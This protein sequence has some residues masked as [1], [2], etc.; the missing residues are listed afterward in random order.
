MSGV[1]TTTV[2]DRTP[3][4]DPFGLASVVA[5]RRKHMPIRLM[6][7]VGVAAGLQLTFGWTWVWAWA[8]L[9]AGGL[10]HVIVD[11]FK[12]N[13]GTGAG[14]PLLPFSAFAIEFPCIS[15]EDVILLLPVNLLVIGLAWGLERVR[16][17]SS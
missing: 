2:V 16:G 5:T 1:E 6:T 11:F 12:D 4:A 10:L 13:L 14:F 3:A 9:Y 17:R 7:A 8:A 15:P